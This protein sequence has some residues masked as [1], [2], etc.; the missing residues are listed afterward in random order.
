M[1]QEALAIQ[2]IG[3][4]LLLGPSTSSAQA[5]R[6]PN[7][8]PQDPLSRAHH[9]PAGVLIGA[10]C[11]LW[12]HYDGAVVH[13]VAAHQAVPVCCG[14]HGQ[15]IPAHLPAD[16]VHGSPVHAVD[17]H[18]DRVAPVRAEASWQEDVEVAGDVCRRWFAGGRGREGSTQQ[19][20][21]QAGRQ[22]QGQ[23]A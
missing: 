15:H 13:L 11:G 23:T 4:A 16:V 2:D 20:G 3:R 6:A 9:A 18:P 1:P 21:R 8:L 17:V 10:G 5:T 7:T 19:P 22:V 14:V 12:V